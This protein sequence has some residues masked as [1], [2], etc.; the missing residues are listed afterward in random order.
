[1]I[2]GSLLLGAAVGWAYAR[3]RRFRSPAW[4]LA[5]AVIA[6]GAARFMLAGDEISLFFATQAVAAVVIVML[7]VSR[8][9]P[10]R[11]RPA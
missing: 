5:Y 9:R 7:A 6:L 1:M 2:V 10:R 8:P 4:V 11:L 3:M